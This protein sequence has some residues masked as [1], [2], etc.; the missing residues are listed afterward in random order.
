MRR[1]L[2]ALITFLILAND[3]FAQHDSL[4][5]FEITS[6]TSI[7]DLLDRKYWQIL[8]DKSNAFDIGSVVHSNSFQT[9]S[10]GAHGI[11]YAI[12]TFWIRY[13]LKNAMTQTVKV[14]LEN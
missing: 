7:P 9:D 8:P 2:F 1:A 11:D 5:T 13:R 6:D 10:S 12:H 3:A 14:C 4:A